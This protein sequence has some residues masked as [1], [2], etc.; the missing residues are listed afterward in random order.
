MCVGAGRAP[1]MCL[2]FQNNF[3]DFEINRN[4]YN[5]NQLTIGQ[6][7]PFRISNENEKQI[8]GRT[9]ASHEMKNDF[10]RFVA[11]IQINTIPV[12]TFCNQNS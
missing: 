7:S 4:C 11:V 5:V 12:Q 8:N 10:D 2:I 1:L 6:R 3:I 9:F